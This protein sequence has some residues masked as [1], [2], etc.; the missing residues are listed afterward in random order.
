MPVLQEEAGPGLRPILGAEGAQVRGIPQAPNARG[1]DLD[2]QQAAARLDHVRVRDISVSG[3]GRVG[4]TD[5]SG[6]QQSYTL[7]L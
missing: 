6:A 1:L 2:R 5:G 3:S 4:A 7:D